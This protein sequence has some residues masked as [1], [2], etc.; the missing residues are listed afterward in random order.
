M[1]NYSNK[2]HEKK[3]GLVGLGLDNKDGHTRIT[4]GDNYYLCGGSEET[5]DRMVETTIKFNENLDRKGKELTDLSKGE[6]LDM[7]HDAS[8]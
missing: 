3:S 7:M 2:N 8:D 6:F 5:H 1:V 4:K